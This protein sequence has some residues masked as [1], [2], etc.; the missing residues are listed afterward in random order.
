LTLQIEGY[1]WWGPTLANNQ[2]HFAAVFSSFGYNPFPG[3]F[4]GLLRPSEDVQ[5]ILDAHQL[6]LSS[7]YVIGVQMRAILRLSKQAEEH[8][9]RTMLFLKSRAESLQTK[10]V[11]FYVC[12]DSK[13]VWD[14][15]VAMFG[16]DI[17]FSASITAGRVGR[18]TKEVHAPFATL[19]L[20]TVVLSHVQAFNYW[21][22]A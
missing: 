16:K 13:E 17:V 11:I 3:L 20:S 18:V 8:V 12:A 22:I 15:T 9:W 2:N 1:D 6:V 19:L 4:N 10:H 7:Y 14:R 5:R 21:I